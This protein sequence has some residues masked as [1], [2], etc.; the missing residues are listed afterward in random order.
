MQILFVVVIVFFSD[1]FFDA[2]FDLYRVPVRETA[3]ECLTQLT[4]VPLCQCKLDQ[5][6][7]QL[8]SRHDWN[9][10]EEWIWLYD[11]ALATQA[12]NHYTPAVIDMALE[13]FRKGDY[14][15][16]GITGNLICNWLR[17]DASILPNNKLDE[18]GEFIVQQLCS[19][20]FLSEW[21]CALKSYFIILSHVLPKENAR[22]QDVVNCMIAFITLIFRHAKQPIQREKRIILF[23]LNSL[24]L[25]LSF[26]FCERSSLSM[27]STS[28]PILSY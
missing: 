21:N 14:A 17:D 1:I 13:W 12:I 6:I 20:N 2:S 24:L 27:Y 9:P 4:L 26:R 7:F 3:C 10:A 23:N 5:I 16:Q 25:A 18:L 19:H 28:S 22:W 8:H 15:T 11:L